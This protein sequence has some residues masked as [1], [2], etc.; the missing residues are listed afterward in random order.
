MRIHY[1]WISRPSSMQ[2]DQISNIFIS[3]LLPQGRSNR[4]QLTTYFKEKVI[5]RLQT[6]DLLRI[7]HSK[8]NI[9]GFALFEPWE[10]GNYYLA[11]MA[12][13]P[14]FQRQG[15]GRKLTFSILSQSR[16]TKKI[17]LMTDQNN[18]PARAFYQAIGFQSSLFRHPD[19]PKNFVGYQYLTS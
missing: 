11:E 9:L 6:P 15:I 12:V 1:H 10:E 5:P 2:I 14:A 4:H 18:H 19:Y 7:A 13:L 17:V 8:H 16:D 3:A